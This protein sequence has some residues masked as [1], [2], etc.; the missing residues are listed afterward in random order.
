M[1]IQVRL[2]KQMDGYIF[3]IDPLTFKEIK[4]EYQK[5]Q[6]ID[7]IFISY[8]DKDD[9]M[10]FYQSTKKKIFSLLLGINDA[11]MKNVEIELIDG[12]SKEK[13]D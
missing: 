7:S 12:V 8:D 13:L 1:N 9:F 5:A 10:T 3:G 4:E 2:F 6:P 11:Q